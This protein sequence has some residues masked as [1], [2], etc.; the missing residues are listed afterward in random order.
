MECGVQNV[1]QKNRALMPLISKFRDSHSQPF[2]PRGAQTLWQPEPTLQ[3]SAQKIPLRESEQ[4]YWE[5]LKTLP[6]GP[7][8]KQ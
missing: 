2:S 6:H 7:L 4:P 8:G 1:K 3:A 5:N